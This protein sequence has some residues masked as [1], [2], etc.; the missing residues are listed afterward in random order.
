MSR[1]TVEVADIPRAQGD[2]FLDRYQQ[3]FQIATVKASGPCGN[4]C[5]LPSELFPRASAF[6]ITSVTSWDRLQGATTGRRRCS[7]VF[8]T[9]FMSPLAG[10]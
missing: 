6:S 2:R 3:D 4:P 7:L 5:T 8:M 9:P 10:S 1:P